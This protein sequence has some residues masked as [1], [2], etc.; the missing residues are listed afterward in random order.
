MKLCRPM[1]FRALRFPLFSFF[2]I[3]DSFRPIFSFP[4]FVR[5]SSIEGFSFATVSRSSSVVSRSL[6]NSSEPR[7]EWESIASAVDG[8]YPPPRDRRPSFFSLFL[9]P[10][11]GSLFGF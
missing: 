7:P 10:F 9:S 1:P 2:R 4:G 3:V 5:G 6:R 8:G 11:F